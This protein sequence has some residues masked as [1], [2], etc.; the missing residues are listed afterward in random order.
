MEKEDNENPSKCLHN[1]TTVV[2]EEFGF[3]SEDIGLDDMWPQELTAS[4]PSPLTVP[5][6]KASPKAFPDILQILPF[7]LF[8][9]PQF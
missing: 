7:L 6:S 1:I 4:D 9:A 2:V 8:L 3:T 5:P